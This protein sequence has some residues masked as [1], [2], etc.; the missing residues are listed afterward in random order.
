M[1]ELIYCGRIDAL[2]QFTKLLELDVPAV[3]LF[4]WNLLREDNLSDVLPSTLRQLRLSDDVLSVLET[5]IQGYADL[6]EKVRDYIK[7]RPIHAPELEVFSLQALDFG[8]NEYTQGWRELKGAYAKVGVQLQY[9]HGEEAWDPFNP[10]TDGNNDDE[11]DDKKTP[12]PNSEDE[13][14][15]ADAKSVVDF[16][17]GDSNV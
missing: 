2:K 6:F 9:F 10:S 17:N 14:Q 3:T 15:V 8:N 5:M 13:E 1:W 16:E 11:R 4:G 7:G 12:F